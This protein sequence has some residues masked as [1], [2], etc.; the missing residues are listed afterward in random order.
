MANRGSSMYDRIMR[1][2]RS[3]GRYEPASQAA[4]GASGG[5]VVG[6]LFKKVGRMVASAVGGGML[7]LR[8]AHQTGYVDIN[9]RKVNR[10]ANRAH[11]QLRNEHPEINSTLEKVKEVVKANAA[12]SVGFASGFLIGMAT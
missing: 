11:R 9:W 8:V 1:S 10:D 6:Y 12:V 3:L 2:T 5:L 4:I 7:I